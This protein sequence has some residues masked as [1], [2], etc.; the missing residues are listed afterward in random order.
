MIEWITIIEEGLRAGNAVLD[1][2]KRNSFV[3]FCN[4]LLKSNKRILLFGSSGSGKSQFIE[5]L[6]NSIN[7]ALR[8]HSTKTNKIPLANLPL[9]FID[10]PGHDQYKFA[11]REEIDKIIKSGVEGII[12]IVSYGY[13]ETGEVDGNT[14]FS[15]DGKIKVKYLES[16]KTYEK[17]QLA[18]WLPRISPNQNVKWIINLVTKADVWWDDKENVQL[19]YEKGDY[20]KEFDQY[21]KFM[22]VIN[23]PYCSLV[24][25]FF[26]EV[27]SSKFGEQEKR[28]LK[29]HLLNELIG[30]LS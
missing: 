9:K 24:K 1:E 22:K 3:S 29:S 19:Y 12:N 5:S 4:Y 23:L 13:H 30:I 20:G 25:P 10:T 18:E 11:R 28:I 26:G 2:T 8:T 7:T 21:R 15:E 17:R 14:V 6:N 27:N 16:N